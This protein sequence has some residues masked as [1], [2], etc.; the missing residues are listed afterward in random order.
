MVLELIYNLPATLREQDIST[1]PLRRRP[2]HRNPLRRRLVL[3]QVRLDEDP[4][5]RKLNKNA[6]FP[7]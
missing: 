2:F 4:F 7:L 5:R 3:P 1:R 6:T